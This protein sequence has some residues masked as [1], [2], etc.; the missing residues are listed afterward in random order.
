M[1]VAM[2][3]PAIRRNVPCNLRRFTACVTY[4]NKT[5]TKVPPGYCNESDLLSTSLPNFASCRIYSTESEISLPMLVDQAPAHVPSLLTPLKLLYLSTLRIA[6]YIDK[7]FD[8]TEFLK[9]A[10]YATAIISKALTNKNYDSLQGLV[11]EDMIEILRAKIETLSPNQR[12]L[13]AVD[14]T[15][16]LF[17]MLSDIDATVGEEHS[18]KITT[19]CHYIQGLAEKKNKMMMSG[20]IDFTTSTKHLVCNYTFTRKYINNIGGP[21][22]ATFVNHYTV[23]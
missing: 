15:D 16:M 20:L 17:Y 14:E 23:S 3:I 1:Q 8:I 9:G 21:W 19:I 11:T 10:K 4:R 5:R 12:Q 13:I 7:E 18:I 22:I 6:P 2:L